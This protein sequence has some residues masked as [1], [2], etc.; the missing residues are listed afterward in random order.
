MR[1][2]AQMLEM[3]AGVTCTGRTA[4]HGVDTRQYSP[5]SEQPAG[6]RT[7]QS[8]AFPRRSKLKCGGVFALVKLVLISRSGKLP[9]SALP[10][11]NR[12][13]K[14]EAREA[15]LVPP[16]AGYVS[17]RTAKPSGSEAVT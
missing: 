1:E 4:V 11:S 16:N 12:S 14:F 13:V 15:R 2:V 8:N 10:T 9:L 7:G 3:T 6:T 5:A 17:L